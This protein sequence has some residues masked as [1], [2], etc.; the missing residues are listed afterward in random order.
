MKKASHWPATIA[1]G[2]ITLASLAVV[3]NVLLNIFGSDPSTKPEIDERNTDIS[4]INNLQEKSAVIADE[5]RYISTNC[6]NTKHKA[7]ERLK[8]EGMEYRTASDFS[9]AQERFS[10]AF[11]L[12][13][14]PEA[15]IA[16]NNSEIGDQLFRTLVVS[17]PFSGSNPNNAV[18]MLRGFAQAQQEINKVG[19]IDGVPLK[20]IVVDDADSESKARHLA[21][22][23]ANDSSYSEIL[24]VVGHW[25]SDVSL[26]AA[27]IY[28]RSESIPFMTPIST[29]K[30]LTNYSDWVYRA[31]INNRSGTRA[32]ADHMLDEWKLKKA[33]IFYVE[34]VTYSEEIRREFK[35]TVEA[36]SGGEIVVEFNM[37]D[38]GF[39]AK[40]SVDK[41]RKAGAEVILLATNNA[42]VPKAHEVIKA[43]NGELKM[44][45][46]AA[47]LYKVETLK[48]VGRAADG[49]VMAIAWDI[50][51]N[52]NQDFVI[53]SRR[54][55]GG[56][57]NHVSAMSYGAI[58]AMAKAIEQSPTRSG[59][60]QALSDSN[61]EVQGSSQAP[62]RFSQGDRQTPPQLVE[63]V[64]V[65]DRSKMGD[66]P[67]LKLDFKPVSQS[68]LE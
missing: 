14:A 1:S 3:G 60:Q 55:W 48:D 29:A 66:I 50:D 34:D 42:S 49:L 12:C 46:D 67:V 61:F 64:E 10:E 8:K 22:T 51:A 6:P 36:E 63:V 25:T 31:T 65:I 47:N 45:G 53:N 19:G 57:V 15:L 4:I 17:V 13:A 52:V 44:L 28:R 54:L 18:E 43:N 20:L 37:G 40:R 9:A 26:A 41:A 56:D 33:A 32:I 23:V 38:A 39:S 2:A 58:K 7:F 68:G 30:E 62:L 59:V 27:A 21:E 11:R 5:S 35:S 24:G 16:H